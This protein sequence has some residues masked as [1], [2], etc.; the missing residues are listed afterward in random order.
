MNIKLSKSQWEAIGKTAG[1]SKGAQQAAQPIQVQPQPQAQPQVQ[2]KSK[3]IMINAIK[4]LTMQSNQ[5]PQN[6]K[7]IRSLLTQ[8]Q[9]LIE[10]DVSM[11]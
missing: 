5:M 8:I 2:N 9:Q 4:T 1:W 3:E 7:Q 6:G 10:N 11:K